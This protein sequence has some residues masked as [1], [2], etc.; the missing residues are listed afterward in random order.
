MFRQWMFLGCLM[1]TGMAFCQSVNY[2]ES[3]V[4]AYTLP[5]PLV[6]EDGSRVETVADWTRRRAEIFRQFQ[7]QMYGFLPEML[8]K[9][10]NHPDFVTFEVVED[11]PDALSGTALRKQVVLTFTNPQKPGQKVTANLLLY[12][13]KH[14]K[15]PV[16]VF[17][18][19]N[20][21]GNHTITPEPEILAF[22][23]RAGN[24]LT[25]ETLAQ[26]EG[27]SARG[28]RVN[29]W[30]VAQILE[31]GYA[32][33]TMH[34]VDVAKDQRNQCFTSGIF[35]LYSD[36]EGETS[37]EKTDWGAITAWA[38]GLSRA[39]DYLETEKL[40]DAK[41]VA[42]MGHSRLGKT[43]LWA[44][45]SDPRF[46]VVISNNSGCGGAALSRREF[47]ETILIMSGGLRYWF[48]PKFREFGERVGDFA[49]DQHELM[50]LMAP[51]PVYVASAEEDRW[52]DPKGEYL[53]CLHAVPVYQIFGIEKPFGDQTTPELPSLNQS[54][55]NVIGYHIRTG[56]HDVTPFDWTQFIQFA[57][58]FL[59]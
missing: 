13:P 7:E 16:P 38:W 11:C 36:Y 48:C 49:I 53:S 31:N 40:V 6:C 50:A 56:I 14:A 26:K 58:R 15:K 12:I 1:V 43:A 44:G 42:V 2:D 8:E 32:L 52:A 29:R 17:L 34:Y 46:A 10:G 9:A 21:M 4:P 39:L 51:R 54:V 5:D 55:G 35:D 22:H 41:K 28:G 20:F 25:E 47:G 57:D 45:A 59:K 37:R 24:V 23:D 18:G 33:A 19:Y 27:T 3:K 30:D